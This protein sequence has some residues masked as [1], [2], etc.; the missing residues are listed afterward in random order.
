MNQN[1]VFDLMG[2]LLIKTMN[3]QSQQFDYHPVNFNEIV[4]LLKAC[5]DANNG[6]YVLSNLSVENYNR[7]KDE[8]EMASLFSF[9]DGMIISGMTPY[10]KPDPRIFSV[11]C[12]TFHLAPETII[13]IDDKLENCLS[14]ETIGITKTINCQ[15]FNLVEIAQKL[16]EFQ[17]LSNES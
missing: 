12:S 10:E 4:K 6:L 17:V 14:A 2:V 15:E 16:L 8:P 1:I 11:F 3:P 5:R 9:F 7:I 13:F